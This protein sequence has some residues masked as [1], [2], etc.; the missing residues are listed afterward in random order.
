MHHTAAYFEATAAAITNSNI[1]ALTD[2]WLTIRDSQFFLPVDVDLLYGTCFGADMTA[3][4]LNNPQLRVITP[5]YLVPVGDAVIPGAEPRV[6]SFIRQP[7]RIPGNQ[8][9]ALEATEATALGTNVTGIVGLR[10]RDEP[11]PS[12]PIYTRRGTGTLTATANAWSLFTPSWDT[13]LPPGMYA[14]VGGMVE[15]ATV[16]GFRYIFTGQVERPGGVGNQATDQ[17][18]HPMFRYGNLGVWG[19]F[20]NTVEPQCEVLCNAADTAQVCYQDVIKIR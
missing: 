1:N 8:N 3:A 15:G 5:T 6:A 18:G 4:R 7:H 17:Q 11:M 16:Q 9:L 10:T 13:T 2:S 14:V 19:V 20:P 12:G